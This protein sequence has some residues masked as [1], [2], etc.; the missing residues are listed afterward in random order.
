MSIVISFWQ[1]LTQHLTSFLSSLFD[2][3]I[4]YFL[5]KNIIYH[6]VMNKSKGFN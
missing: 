1:F 5:L 6:I 2:I 4:K 3:F